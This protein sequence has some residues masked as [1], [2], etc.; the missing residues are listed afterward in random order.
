MKIGFDDE[1]DWDIAI[2]KLRP[3][4]DL[5]TIVGNI[6]NIIILL[7]L[8]EE[9][10]INEVRVVKIISSRLRS[11]KIM[12]LRHH[13]MEMKDKRKGNLRILEISTSKVDILLNY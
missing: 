3:I 8:V 9:F 5:I 13:I 4:D 7:K 12:E 6:I 11:I 10:K 1:W 2:I